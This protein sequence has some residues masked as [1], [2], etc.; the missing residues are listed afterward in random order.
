MNCE[1]CTESVDD[2]KHQVMARQRMGVWRVIKPCLEAEW[3]MP[4]EGVGGEC[5][6]SEL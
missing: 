2:S 5:V 4:G 3:M 6:G 1:A